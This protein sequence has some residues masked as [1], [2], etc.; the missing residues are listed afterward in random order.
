EHPQR[1]AFGYEPN[2]GWSLF[3]GL[4]LHVVLIGP[5]EQ[6]PPLVW[7][8]ACLGGGSGSDVHPEHWRRR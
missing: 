7:R 2:R 5:A 6:A 1:D 8:T 4:I 3:E